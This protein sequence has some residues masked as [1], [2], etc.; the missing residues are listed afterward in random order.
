MKIQINDVTA[1]EIGKRFAVIGPAGQCIGYFNDSKDAIK[2]ATKSRGRVVHITG[3]K[4]HEHSKLERKG[5]RIP[6]HNGLRRN[7]IKDFEFPQTYTPPHTTIDRVKDSYVPGIRK[8]G[9]IRESPLLEGTIW[10]IPEVNLPAPSGLEYLPHQIAGI[11]AMLRKKNVLLADEQGLGKT[12]E[13][14]GYINTI[15]PDRTV[16]VCPGIAVSN[17][18]D[19]L[20]LWLVDKTKKVCVLSRGIFCSIH[21]K[22]L[23]HEGE[24]TYIFRRIEDQKNPDWNIV[25]CKYDEFSLKSTKAEKSLYKEEKVD[26]DEPKERKKKGEDATVRSINPRVRAICKVFEKNLDV[27]VLDECHIVKNVKTQFTMAFFGEPYDPLKPDV[28]PYPGLASFAKRKIFASGT[29][30]VGDKPIELFHILN[31]LDP[32]SFSSVEEFKE[33]F[34][35]KERKRKNFPPPP[36][37]V[38]ED[39]LAVKLRD[40]VLLRRTAD[41]VLELPPMLIEGF[42]L[43]ETPEVISARELLE[44]A[45]IDENEVIGEIASVNAIESAEQEITENDDDDDSG[46]ED[47]EKEEGELAVLS[48]LMMDKTISIEEKMMLARRQ[49]SL[50]AKK[51]S[52]VSKADRKY[53]MVE[54]TAARVMLGIA[55]ALQFE[56]IYDWVQDNIG[57]KNGIKNGKLVIFYIYKSTGDI[58]QKKLLA[59]KGPNGKP[60]YTEDQIVRIDSKTKRSNGYRGSLVRKF[61]KNPKVKIFLGTIQTCSTAITLTAANTSIFIELDWRPGY[62]DQAMKRTHRYSKDNSDTEAVFEIM[63]YVDKSVDANVFM[64]LAHKRG[65]QKSIL[66]KF[67]GIEFRTTNSGD[68]E[69]SVN[70]YWQDKK[71]EK[72][73][74]SFKSMPIPGAK[75]QMDQRLRISKAIFQIARAIETKEKDTNMKGGFVDY[76]KDLGISFDESLKIKNFN[77]KNYEESWTYDGLKPAMKSKQFPETK[78]QVTYAK[79]IC[80]DELLPLIW[81]AKKLV[82]EKSLVMPSNPN[83]INFPS[84]ITGFVRGV[85]RPVITGQY[86]IDSNPLHTI[87]YAAIRPMRMGLIKLH[88]DKEKE[89][90]AAAGVVKGKPGRKPKISESEKERLRQAALE[91]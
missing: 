79:P 46:D 13:I 11:T 59:M 36:P 30:M 50:Y 58:V 9:G 72:Y 20:N 14:I 8:I 21:K 25:V 48:E 43:E 53:K 40:T 66:D 16:I 6:T 65:V 33:D 19:E 4:S 15:Q 12:M 2:L 85:L 80:I 89:E 41:D 78:D 64:K 75:Y 63:P 28:K 47:S 90:D 38:N 91:N 68:S 76:E 61:Q 81:K 77:E 45:E 73:E 5:L 82:L 87:L 32:A 52:A 71:I 42:P 54:M 44:A 27:I 51:E 84:D 3:N 35:N 55:K 23:E 39:M 67:P 70:Q 49:A 34:V 60:L 69:A 57:S 37:V 31:S 74:K 18:I 83:G 29:P 86:E 62:V 24:Y 26:E 17:W 22:E 10:P 88:K 56:Y 7:P 1:F